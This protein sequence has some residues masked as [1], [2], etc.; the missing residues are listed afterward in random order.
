MINLQNVTLSHKGER[1]F[2][3]RHLNLSLPRGS[4]SWLVGPSGAGKSSLLELL[5]LNTLPTQG[6][7]SVLDTP[8]ETASRS[9]LRHLRRR[10][11]FIPQ[12]YRLIPEWSIFDNIALPLRL[13]RHREPDI[14]REVHAILN[15]LGLTHHAEAFPSQLSGGEQQRVAIARALIGRPALLIA[16]EPT[17][18]LGEDQAHLLLDAMRQL[19]TLGTTVIVATHSS[20]LMRS[21]PAPSL[22]LQNGTLTPT[23]GHHE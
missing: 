15:W 10:I 7:M 1:G 12:N 21:F 11:G 19:I 5:S 2:T 4:F 3:L 18:A 6:Q 9:A 20:A 14:R 13:H 16:D 23:G 8:V 17:H 22:S